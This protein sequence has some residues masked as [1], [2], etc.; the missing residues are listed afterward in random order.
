MIDLYGEHVQVFEYPDARRANAEAALVS[1][2]G[3]TVGTTKPHWLGPPHFFKKGRL[4][5]LY[6]GDND[7]VVET[8][9]RALGRPFAGE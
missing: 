3:R 5:V 8:L 6:V 2:D 1:P 7:K 4:I 9:S